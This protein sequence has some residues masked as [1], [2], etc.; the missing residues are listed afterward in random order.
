VKKLFFFFDY[1]G[2]Q[3]SPQYRLSGVPLPP[4]QTAIRGSPQ[5]PSVA[6]RLLDSHS[7]PNVYLG[8]AGLAP[9]ATTSSSRF[10]TISQRFI[11]NGFENGGSANSIEPHGASRMS[12]RTTLSGCAKSTISSVLWLTLD[13]R[14]LCARQRA[15]L[16]NRSIQRPRFA[17]AAHRLRVDG[18]FSLVPTFTAAKSGELPSP[19][20]CRHTHQDGMNILVD[21]IGNFF[22]QFLGRLPVN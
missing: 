12:P 8:K 10:A 15:R 18:I 13:R 2:K 19:H 7:K 20:T 17:R 1:D 11:G 21:K 3:H 4:L 5:L 16:A 14:C 6:C 9:S 22:R